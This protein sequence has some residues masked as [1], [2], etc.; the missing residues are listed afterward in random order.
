MPTLTFLL[1]SFLPSPPLDYESDNRWCSSDLTQRK[2]RGPSL[3]AVLRRSTRKSSSKSEFLPESVESDEVQSDES[4]PSEEETRKRNKFGSCSSRNSLP[5]DENCDLSAKKHYDS[6]KVSKRTLNRDEGEVKATQ[7]DAELALLVKSV[8]I[9]PPKQIEH[10][11]YEFK[12]D[13]LADNVVS[14][15]SFTSEKSNTV[16]KASHRRWKSYHKDKR[17]WKQSY[18]AVSTSES[19]L[20]KMKLKDEICTSRKSDK[21]RK[22]FKSLK[23]NRILTAYLDSQ[24]KIAD[25]P[26]KEPNCPPGEE[27]EVL[28]KDMI[29][30]SDAE[31]GVGSIKRAMNVDDDDDGNG[32]GQEEANE[33]QILED[34]NFNGKENQSKTSVA[35]EPVSVEG[36]E[37][38]KLKRRRKKGAQEGDESLQKI[39]G[40]Q[41]EGNTSNVDRERHHRKSKRNWK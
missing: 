19:Q 14:L 37:R 32:R 21:E 18:A 17:K 10:E 11:L 29:D 40:E 6:Q 2:K 35:T 27:D 7:L 13:P 16:S 23:K 38:A 41:F 36:S 4:S 39:P 25:S 20:L 30:K 8:D 9:E 28:S 26:S 12:E 22:I 15:C 31:T 5:Y 24:N 1:D 33:I 3:R 34:K